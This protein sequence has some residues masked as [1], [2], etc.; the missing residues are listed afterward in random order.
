MTPGERA[1]LLAVCDRLYVC[2]AL[3]S[4]CAE[5]KTV[6]T[7]LL[8]PLNPDADIVPA[9]LPVAQVCASG[10]RVQ[11]QHS[12]GGFGETA[13]GTMTPDA[14]RRYAED[15]LAAADAAEAKGKALALREDHT[16]E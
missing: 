2:S 15:I 10:G 16:D 7:H 8:L 14:A 11:I 6:K 3:L 9:K 1:F 5:R 13:G 12:R 4:R